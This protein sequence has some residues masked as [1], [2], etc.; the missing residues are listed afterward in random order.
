M[1][2]SNYNNANVV[3]CDEEEDYENEPPLLEELGIRFDHI[4][5]KTKVV[6]NPTKVSHFGFLIRHVFPNIRIF[7]Y[8]IWLG[9]RCNGYPVCLVCPVCPVCLVCPG[10]PVCPVVWCVLWC[11]LYRI[12]MS[13]CSMMPISPVLWCT[14][15]C[16][17]PVYCCLARCV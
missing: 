2:Y 14:V 12:L 16:W 13:T 5:D 15:C 4:W 10:C 17:A 6:I 7:K 11:V 3:G 1:N 9:T 8:Y